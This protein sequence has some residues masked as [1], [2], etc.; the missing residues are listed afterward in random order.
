MR[1]RLIILVLFL[2]LPFVMG[3]GQGGRNLI[4]I[5]NI[6]GLN[7]SGQGMS[8]QGM[9]GLNDFDISP[10][11]KGEGWV[12]ATASADEHE[13][14]RRSGYSVKVIDD[15]A[16]SGFYY[17]VS[18]REGEYVTGIPAP[19]RELARV[20]EGVIVKS[21]IDDISALS[22]QGIGF[23]RIHDIEIPL[24]EKKSRVFREI[25]T[26]W[27][28]PENYV[29]DQV[30]DSTITEY[31]TRLVAFQTRYTYTDSIYAASQYIFDKFTE[32]GY[33]NVYFDSLYFPGP[34]QRN[35]VAVKFGTMLPDRVIVIGG[36]YDSVTFDGNCDPD[37]LAPGADDDASG[38]AVTMELARILADL[39]T[40]VSV[41]FVAFAAEE[42]GLWGS[43][44]FAQQAY[45]QGMDIIVAISLDMLA[46]EA[47]NDW[48][49]RLNVE[50]PANPFAQ[51]M[52][53]MAANYTDIT[54]Q[55]WTPLNSQ[56]DHYPFYQLGYDV[57]FVIE[58]DYSPN[59]HLC[60]DIIE[61]LNLP[62]CTDAAEMMAASLVF[63][64]N[65]PATPAGLNIANVG[66][67]TSLR[68]GWEPNQESDL[69]GYNI[70]YGTQSGV[71]DSLKTA[72]PAAVADTLAGLVDGTTFYIA[73]SAFDIDGYESFLTAE[74]E[75]M[76]SA[77]PSPP[78]GLVSTSL[79]SSIFLEWDPN[80]DDLD[81]IGY[82][83][84][85]SSPGS[86][87]LFLGYVPVPTTSIT[88]DSAYPHI[89]YEYW[90]T[91]VDNQNPP[92]ESEFSELAYG[93]LA[94]RDMGILVVDNTRDGSGNPLMPTDVEV[95]E[96]Y[97]SLLEG[98]DVQAVWDVGDSTAGGRTVMDYDLGIYSCV[99]WHSDVRLGI[100]IAPCTAAM[101]KYLDVGGDLWLS[102]WMLLQSITDGDPPFSFEEG[103]FVYD[104]MGVSS[105]TTTS[106]ADVDFIGAESIEPDFSSLAVDLNKTP[107]GAL[108]STDCL[109]PPFE[110]TYPIYSYVSS[111]GIG[112]QY[113]GLPISLASSSTDYGLVVTDFPLFFM[114]EADAAV[115]TA[116]VM[117]HFGEPVGIEDEE[118]VSFP[119]THALSQ[120]FPNPF[121]PTTTISFAIPEPA[122]NEPVER[123]TNT[124]LSVFDVRGRLVKVLVDDELEPGDY[125]VTWNGK[126]ESGV[127]VAS[128]IYF[129]RIDAGEFNSTRKMTII[130]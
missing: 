75:I 112:S 63:I 66:D 33:T 125:R 86:E 31:L 47:D 108:F 73:I 56:S 14:L 114:D 102:G 5:E 95:D 13:P 7:L 9:N 23:V 82:N 42:Q 35:V 111:E 96:F 84:Y 117:E 55:Y 130:K 36:H 104:Y 115:L 44:H 70:Y 46:N 51:V 34:V 38:T 39:D 97:A 110:G 49:I 99:V 80:E 57:V 58:S 26:G 43:S 24:R 37:T 89:L 60:T 72:G 105:A 109:Y 128:G 3:I 123:T 61:N 116:E 4:L 87:P 74:T 103:D 93:R 71:Y 19:L 10:H 53:A 11:L 85:R 48:N 32:F 45:N 94:T 126:S 77:I 1:S 88:D 18:G 90:V 68:L 101:R 12:L 69:S 100:S 98:Y 25:P 64:A 67:G 107:F 28:G 20:P 6:D 21:A 30:S 83:V 120:N 122:S 76:V 2:S 121:N 78:T 8:G 62:Y 79:E 113:H 16:W 129:Y 91:S 15:V 40:D 41:I 127:P 92:F 106:N 54:A 59:V 118:I 52:E 50:S 22:R 119:R 81:L 29:V 65:T 124:T 17:L 27:Y